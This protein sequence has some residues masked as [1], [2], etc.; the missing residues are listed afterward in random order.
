MSAAELLEFLFLLKFYAYGAFV[1]SRWQ[2]LISVLRFEFWMEVWEIVA[3]MAVE[4][5]LSEDRALHYDSD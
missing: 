5:E 2:N 4:C 3:C 1:P